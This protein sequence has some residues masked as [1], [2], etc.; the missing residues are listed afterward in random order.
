MSHRLA[1]LLLAVFLQG[2]ASADP[3]PRVVDLPRADGGTTTLHLSG[4]RAGC[5]DTI[6]LSHGLGGDPTRTRALSDRLAAAGWRVG[7]MLHAESGPG[8]LRR[9]LLSADR[10]AALIAAA[11]DPNAHEARRRDLDAAYAHVTLNCRP[12]RLVLV[13]H[14]MGA[15]TTMVEAGAT[16]RFGG[17]GQDRFD[18]YVA[19]SPQGIGTVYAPGAFAGV[20][21]PVLMVTGTRDQGMDGDWTTRL[22]A[23]EA[24]PAG[25]RRLAILDGA[26]HIAIGGAFGPVVSTISQL[27]DAFARG[28]RVTLTGVTQRER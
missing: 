18:A 7:S 20:R 5:P 28:D 12:R 4:E 16:P 1:A 23:F 8:S 17:R 11:T 6:I 2:Q 26:G 19:L 27:I 22:S 10:R 24:L 9:I 3:G 13:G 21:K 25:R 15:M 14:S